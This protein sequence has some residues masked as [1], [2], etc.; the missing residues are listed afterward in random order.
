M[1]GKK[2]R[3]SMI[4]MTRRV[5]FSAAHADWLPNLSNVENA[6]LFGPGASPEPYGHNYTLDVSV[7]GEIEPKTGIVINIK[8][9]DRIVKQWVVQVLDK[10]FINKQ[11][12]AFC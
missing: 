8:E 1:P 12:A 11:V 10:K 7:L 5:T 4:T 6:A 9:I 2:D 3:M